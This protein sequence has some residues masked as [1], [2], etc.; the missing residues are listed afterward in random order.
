MNLSPEALQKTPTAVRRTVFSVLWVAL[1]AQAVW[2]VIHHL[3]LHES[4]RES[5]RNMSYPFMFAVPFVLLALTGG[6]IRLIN[7]A[8]RLPVAIAFLDAVADRLGLL[9]PHGAPG[10]AWG[11]F[12]HFI[13]YTARINPFMPAATIPLLAVLAT[14]GETTFAVA[15]LLGIRIRA[16]A[17]GSAALLLLFGTAMTISGFSQFEYG[18][19]LM[20]VGMLALST[21]DAS[22]L[23]LDAFTSSKKI[24]SA[25]HQPTLNQRA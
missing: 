7:A 20:A 15:L 2:M 17:I 11:D 19:Y 25:Q 13:A 8:L 18:V 3:R 23:S 9:G 16:A 4:L 6:H 14:V 5:L 22:L 24:L 12:A 10:V 21:V 1:L